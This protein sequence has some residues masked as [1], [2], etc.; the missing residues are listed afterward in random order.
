MARSTPVGGFESG[1]LAWDATAWSTTFDTYSVQTKSETARSKLTVRRGD[2]T[3]TAA[4]DTGS[5]QRRQAD[6]SRQQLQ[7]DSSSRRQQQRRDTMSTVSADTSVLYV[8]IHRN[9]V[10]QPNGNLYQHILR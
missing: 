8:R 9:R 3:R 2:Q 1:G 4:A 5:R 6:S 10:D 7:T